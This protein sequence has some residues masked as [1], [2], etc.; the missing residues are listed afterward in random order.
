MFS[1]IRANLSKFSFIGQQKELGRIRKI[2]E[3]IIKEGDTDKNM[4]FIV[5]GCVE[6]FRTLPN[7]NRISLGSVGQG[8]IVG[9][10]AMFEN[11]P[12]SASV[13]VTKANTRILTIDGETL[14]RNIQD[15]P[16]L[17]IMILRKMSERLRNKNNEIVQHILLFNQLIKAHLVASKGLITLTS[18]PDTNNF[19]CPSSMQ[20][21]VAKLANKLREWGKFSEELTDDFIDNL[22]IAG[23]LR[24][25]GNESIPKEILEKR[26]HLT[27]E[28]W[29]I[30][31]CH[32]SEGA[33]ALTKAA[34]QV[35]EKRFLN[36]AAEISEFHHEHYDG[37]GYHGLQWQEIPLSARIISVVD[38]YNALTT[39]RPYREKLSSEEAIQLINSES[40]T[41]FDPIIVQAFLAVMAE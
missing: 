26:S 11:A 22:I 23:T 41:H 29:R 6:V 20:I 18:N 10:M 37:T 17:A 13:R 40:G 14:L 16:F 33:K 32:V 27:S 35:E 2:G 19:L 34:E 39:E 36:L 31:K 7:N 9:E 1:K 3:L 8:E 30:V 21:L 5:S 12:R 38:V 15:D 25:I 4:Y 24:D 28:E